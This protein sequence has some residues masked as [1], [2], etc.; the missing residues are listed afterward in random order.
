MLFNTAYMCS[1][2][3][4]QSVHQHS[5]YL[6]PSVLSVWNHNQQQLLPASE[7]PLAMH[8]MVVMDR[9]TV[10]DTALNKGRHLTSKIQLP[11]E[12]R[13]EVQQPFGALELNES[14]STF[15]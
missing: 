5:S 14:S 3:Y 8:C 7:L 2:H 6:E 15:S 1:M 4:R 9:L 12:Q 13:G 10:Q 11:T